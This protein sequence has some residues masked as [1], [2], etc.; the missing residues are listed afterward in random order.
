MITAHDYLTEVEAR[1]DAATNGP[2]QA[3]TTGPRK[4]DHWHV[5]DSG[6]SI[7]LI[8]ASDGEDE[9]T[10]QCDADF[11]AAARSDLPR[12][13]AALRAVLDLLEPVKITGEMQSYE[14][15]QAEGYN[16]ALRD[17]ADTIT[18]KLGVGE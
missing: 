9:D 15:H 11:I 4:G 12:M 3:I 5:T 2:W 8:H 14:I 13:T 18:E 16:E 1:A 7:A 10:R 17:L 6:Q